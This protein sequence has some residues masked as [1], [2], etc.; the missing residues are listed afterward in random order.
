MFFIESYDF[1]F[2]LNFPFILDLL[3]FHLNLFLIY[4]WS[5]YSEVSPHTGQ[6][7]HHQKIYKQ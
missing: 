2:V 7:V 6:N 5:F 3:S 1:T 4:I